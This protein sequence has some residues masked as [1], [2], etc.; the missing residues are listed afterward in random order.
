MNRRA[1]IRNV[2]LLSAGAALLPSCVSNDKTAS[3]PLKNLSLTAGEEDMLAALSEAII[4]KTKDFIGAAE[5][6]THEFVLTMVDDC[7][8]PEDQQQFTKGM[9]QFAAA[10]EKKMNSSFVSCTP[11]QKKEF[12]QLAEKKQDIPED[13][14]KFYQTTKQYT[15]QSFTSSKEYMTDIRNYKMVPGPDYKGCVPV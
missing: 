13:A 5:L 6:K 12:L 4:P 11:A 15:L 1:A 14:L 2:I 9:K 10:C 8:S 7:H 3:I